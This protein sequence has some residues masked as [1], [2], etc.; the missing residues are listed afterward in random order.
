MSIPDTLQR[1]RI[2]TDQNEIYEQLTEDLKIFGGKSELFLAA[3]VFGVINDKKSEKKPKKTYILDFI[4]L[5]RESQDLIYLL[6]EVCRPENQEVSCDDI[7]RYA[8]G[9]LTLIWEAYRNQGV[10]DMTRLAEEVKEKWPK[11]LE[12]LNIT[13]RKTDLEKILEERESA[14]VEYKSSMIWD[15]NAKRENKKLL[16]SII[17]R[18]VASFMN[19]NGGRLLIGISDDKQ[20]LGIE[21]DL[22]VLDKHTI[23]Q[24]IQHYTNIIENYLGVKNTLNANIKFKDVNGKTIAIVEI[25][26]KA[27]KP[28]YYTSDDEEEVFFIRANNTSRKLPN[29]EVPDYIKQHW[30][31]LQ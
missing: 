26:K 21:K 23:D 3:L 22:N 8:D 27:P 19:V 4:K 10:L 28:V 5:P 29:S 11:R 9:G 15:Y 16:G 31:E 13:T 1:M 24:F 12:E 2:H 17:A 20:V 14:N 7:V 6:S 25:P 18:T 30:P